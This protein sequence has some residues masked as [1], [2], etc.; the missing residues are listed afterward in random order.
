M[1]VAVVTMTL[2]PRRP[3]AP[4][5][6]I[7]A[8]G[9]YEG[10]TSDG[11][12]FSAIVL[13][14]D[15]A[16]ALYGTRSPTGTLYVAGILHATGGSSDGTSYTASVKDYFYT[17]QV[18]TGLLSANYVPGQS[19]NGTLTT[20]GTTSKFN[21]TAIATTD[22]NYAI[23]A[24]LSDTAGT[25]NGT[26][27]DGQSGSIT[28]ATNGAYIG[29]IG[30]CTLSGQ[31]TPRTSGKNVFDVT[32]T[33]GGAPCLYPNITTTGIAVTYKITGG[34]QLLIAGTTPDQSAGTAFLANR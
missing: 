7:K 29:S 6:V 14:N 3:P 34:N 17:G 26:T 22:Y 18:F 4:A 33:F 19:F 2:L 11:G 12:S 23:P 10:S 13:E 1:L 28:V 20:T 30:G 16:W 8:E 27:I 24:N 31:L 15:E 5:P 21:A 25:W 32:T 9:A